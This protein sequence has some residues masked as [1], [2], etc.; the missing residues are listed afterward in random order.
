MWEERFESSRR[1]TDVVVGEARRL[2]EERVRGAAQ[3][4]A[5]V[6]IGAV[7]RGGV[8][9][10][11]SRRQAVEAANRKLDDIDKVGALLSTKFVVPEAT[12]VEVA[13]VAGYGACGFFAAR[14]A[15]DP[16]LLQRCCATLG[17]AERRGANFPPFWS[18]FA[19]LC[20]LGALEGEYALLETV[21]KVGITRSEAEL[22]AEKVGGVPNSWNNVEFVAA[23]P[24]AR[25][26]LKFS[27]APGVLALIP[28]ES[29]PRELAEHVVVLPAPEA[30]LLAAIALANA[31]SVVED[32]RVLAEVA[33][34]LFPK[35]PLDKLLGDEKV[36]CWETRAGAKVPAVAP[37]K[38]VAKI[39]RLV[40]PG[41]LSRFVE[42]LVP[43]RAET[44][45]PTPEDDRAQK[46][47]KTAT[48][49]VVAKKRRSFV[50][51]LLGWAREETTMMMPATNKPPEPRLLR[52]RKSRTPA[53][54]H[55]DDVRLFCRL[56][57]PLLLAASSRRRFEAL[58]CLAFHRFEVA[59]A[60]FASASARLDDP[61]LIVLTLVL[62]HGLLGVDDDELD[63]K[64]HV[65]PFQLRRLVLMLKQPLFDSCWKRESRDG[66]H[67]F[68]LLR[69]LR[70]RRR[71]I[72]LPEDWVVAETETLLQELKRKTDRA[73]RVC[74][75]MPQCVPFRDRAELVA[76]DAKRTSAKKNIRIRRERVLEDGLEQLAR[77]DDMRHT[78]I[79]VHFV[80]SMGNVESGID[81]GGLWK[82]LVV[83][84][85]K[86]AF[87]QEF[88]LFKSCAE[89]LLYPNPD[90]DVI[91]PN[92]YLRLFDFV[93]RVLGKAISESIPVQPRFN[94][95][96][97][98]FIIT[99]DYNFFGLLDELKD[100]DPE[101][102]K[103]LKFLQTYDGDVGDLGLTFSATLDRLGERQER[104]LIPG[105]RDVPVGNHNRHAYVQL[106]AKYH[107]VDRLRA[108]SRAFVEGMAKAI[109]LDLLRLFS[110]PELQH[111]ISG[112]DDDDLDVDDLIKH[113][114]YEGFNGI[115]DSRVVSRFWAVVR[116]LSRADRASLLKFATSCERP[117]PL[118]FGALEPPFTIR[119]VSDPDRLPTAATCFN[120]L[121]LPAYPTQAILK[122]KLLTSI[123]AQAGFDLT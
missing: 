83:E 37:D 7:V 91:H 64:T 103:N 46:A 79:V 1:T 59:R 52:G 61:I 47:L 2:R 20:W 42:A 62:R 10:R 109:D 100:L 101:L 76:A 94:R 121:K 74:R 15:D 75:E 9:R 25:V 71:P 4:A 68:R 92:S 36:V 110:E 67:A 57:A 96:F 24:C 69:D 87:A 119:K 12:A 38:L 60:L 85:C 81:S 117:P 89:G 113:T 93:G 118:G 5:A 70:S 31:A 114:R 45:P 80:D 39:S 88:G 34:R 26:A 53:A 72:A 18:R 19:R 30:P 104:D 3:G 54:P 51:E 48:A 50:A 120:T 122:T 77:I 11:V 108:P 23:N 99:A 95:S 43:R 21:E 90:A 123:R 107:L 22:V 33:I 82:E 35:I 106:V 14:A 105:G 29:P 58:T 102:H 112:P 41:L 32:P 65:A 111:L 115:T 13:R 8:C 56:V 49:V 17:V 6:R 66:A 63:E 44:D 98:R 86:A 116:S 73:T 97:L 16:K 40:E 27:A 55:D 28:W 84:V 78:R